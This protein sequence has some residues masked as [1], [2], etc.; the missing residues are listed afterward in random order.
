VCVR[1]TS[2][3]RGIFTRCLRCYRPALCVIP[4][5]V[6]RDRYY[7]KDNVDGD[8]AA[9]KHFSSNK[10]KGV[11]RSLYT[12][13]HATGKFDRLPREPDIMFWDPAW[14]RERARAMVRKRKL[15]KKP[16]KHKRLAWLGALLMTNFAT[17][18]V[19]TTYCVTT[20]FIPGW[21]RLFRRC[22]VPQTERD[23]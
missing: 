2:R 5:P 7:F 1:A 3:A 20:H 22:F 18:S 16:V 23:C 8:D 13:A 6:L 17:P 12:H 4:A 10:W 15:L 21:K 9:W 19:R 14:L 11:L